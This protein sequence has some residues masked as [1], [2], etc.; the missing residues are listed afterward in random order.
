ML[1]NIESYLDA[2]ETIYV[3]KVDSLTTSSGKNRILI[4]GLYM[5]GVTQKNVLSS[6]NLWMEKINL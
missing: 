2:G 1:S 5:Y 6:G 4:E 3:G